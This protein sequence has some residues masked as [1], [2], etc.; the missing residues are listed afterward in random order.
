MK[1]FRI[2]LIYTN[3]AEMKPIIKMLHSHHNWKAH[4]NTNPKLTHAVAHSSSC[5]KY[6]LYRYPLET[7]IPNNQQKV[8]KKDRQEAE[9]EKT[10]RSR[11][12]DGRTG[13]CWQPVNKLKTENIQ[14][15]PHNSYCSDPKTTTSVPKIIKIS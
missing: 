6:L 12:K 3:K 13:R 2:L 9:K 4:T 1:V 5:C 7:S 15:K 11:I 14:E 10:L 8:I